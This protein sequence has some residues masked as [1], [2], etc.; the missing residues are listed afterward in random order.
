MSTSGENV[1][2]RRGN[3]CKGRSVLVRFRKSPEAGAGRVSE[4]LI[5]GLTDH[6]IDFGLD[7]EMLHP[8]KWTCSDLDLTSLALA[9]VW[10]IDL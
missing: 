8:W 3:R 9:A 5:R 1:S 2:G 7:P 6:C 10:R 4:Q